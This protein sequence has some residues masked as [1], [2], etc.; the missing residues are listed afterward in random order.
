[1]RFTHMLTFIL[2]LSLLFASGSNGSSTTPTTPTTS[3]PLTMQYNYSEPL[4]PQIT[5]KLND[6]SWKYYTYL[7]GQ[8]IANPTATRNNL[9]PLLAYDI[10]TYLNS[11]IYDSLSAAKAEAQAAISHYNVCDAM[12]IFNLD[13]TIDMKGSFLDPLTSS[14]TSMSES[15]LSSLSSYNSVMEP[16]LGYYVDTYETSHTKTVN[17][18]TH[19]YYTT[20]YRL[21]SSGNTRSLT[22]SELPSFLLMSAAIAT[23]NPVLLVSDVGQIVLDG[24]SSITDAKTSCKLYSDKYKLAWAGTQDAMSL[25]IQNADLARQE[26]IS[27]YED[28][29]NRGFCNKDYTGPGA[30]SCATLKEELSSIQYNGREL[31]AITNTSKDLEGQDYPYFGDAFDIIEKA[32][33]FTTRVSSLADTYNSDLAT[34]YTD[35]E[36]MKLNLSTRIDYMKEKRL[37]AYRQ[38]AFYIDALYLEGAVSST[39]TVAEEYNDL[40]NNIKS[41][42]L[43]LSTIDSMESIGAANYSYDIYEGLS[44]YNELL[45]QEPHIVEHAKTVLSK[46]RERLISKMDSLLSQGYDVEKYKDMLSNA[47]GEPK[48]GSRYKEYVRIDSML[49]AVA[50]KPPMK[51]DEYLSLVDEVKDLLSRASKD[52]LDVSL[53]KSQLSSIDSSSKSY[54]D[55]YA[56]LSSVEDS[57]LSKAYSR[58]SSLQTYK[59]E[60]ESLMATG[61]YSDIASKKT[62]L[63]GNAVKVDSD[64]IR[65]NMGK[66]LEL[67]NF[68]KDSI[69]TI[70]ERLATSFSA[71]KVE[72]M[73]D[74]PLVSIDEEGTLEARAIITNPLNYRFTDVEKTIPIQGEFYTEEVNVDRGYVIT[75]D[76]ILWRIPYIEPYE[77]LT[78][79]IVKKDKFIR[80]ISLNESAEADGEEG[81]LSR[82]YDVEAIVDSTLDVGCDCS[83]YVDGQF[84]GTRKTI[85][86]DKG[87][88][89]IKMLEKKKL[90]DISNTTLSCA[91]TSGETLCREQMTISPQYDI[92]RAVVNINGYEVEDG[93][94]Y[95]ME[96]SSLVLS[97]LEAGKTY[98]FTLK[99]KVDDV[100]KELS[101]L[102]TSLESTAAPE[103]NDTLQEIKNLQVS[104]F[105]DVALEKA[106]NL[107]DTIEKDNKISE[108]KKAVEEELQKTIEADVANLKKAVSV[109]SSLS[110][111]LSDKEKELETSN[112]STYDKSWVKRYVSLTSSQ[113]WKKYYNL[114]K[115]YLKSMPKNTTLEDS[116]KEFEA[117]HRKAKSSYDIVSLS[118]AAKALDSAEAIVGSYKDKSK[119]IDMA[120]SSVMAKLSDAIAGYEEMEREAKKNDLE[121]Y[122]PFSSSYFKNKL[123]LISSAKTARQKAMLTKKGE[124]LLSEINRAK[125]SLKEAASSEIDNTENYLRS[126]GISEEQYGKSLSLAKSALDEG[127]Y[128][129]VLSITSQMKK[130]AANLAPPMK[131]LS[132]YYPY[133]VLGVIAIGAGLYLYKDRL[134]KKKE[135]PKRRIKRFK[136]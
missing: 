136:D 44:T 29:S 19:T 59:E 124:S 102:L 14:L 107:S 130:N 7:D 90:L 127:Q 5:L 115:D 16:S 122:L 38:E 10:P 131:D 53:E 55:K 28:A 72:L 24:L 78:A 42:E 39:K 12:F 48:L 43:F 103:Y 80:Q 134:F 96:G 57:I 93:P 54:I 31:L 108:E 41:A 17:N 1:M 66:L 9:N 94:S 40:D 117:E 33:N 45:S 30:V 109:G 46:F 74:R 35:V 3:S 76:N 82:E 2:M 50:A 92:T 64:F 84:K 101:T 23:A 113:L 61:T 8:L 97:N 27:M 11:S 89:T 51:K 120:Y 71:V 119:D 88:H 52:G 18:K 77:S 63:E 4:N 15:Q 34:Y 91:T 126:S 21:V 58:F 49:D 13:K 68:Y 114:K 83:V 98:V 22:S 70:E 32:H 47:D 87:F 6:P 99:T 112:A 123:K 110:S 20:H 106:K 85:N 62:T 75:G 73:Y 111:E 65:S 67:E 56:L 133:A 104:G 95:E 25:A 81:Q 125:D 121:E 79:D 36:A 132:D 118:K 129:K 135:I 26:L 128:V 100:N 105:Y 60:L 69:S 86:L 37:E 116:F